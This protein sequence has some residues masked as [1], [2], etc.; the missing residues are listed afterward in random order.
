MHVNLD[1]SIVDLE[2]EASNFAMLEDNATEWDA[3]AE[4]YLNGRVLRIIVEKN[5]T[6]KIYSEKKTWWRTFVMKM[7]KWWSETRW[8][9][10]KNYEYSLDRIFAKD[11]KSPGCPVLAAAS[12]KVHNFYFDKFMKKKKAHEMQT[13]GANEPERPAVPPAG[14][15]RGASGRGTAGGGGSD[16]Y[17]KLTGE[18]GPEPSSGGGAGGGAGGVGSAPATRVGVHVGPSGG[19]GAGAVGGSPVRGGVGADVGGRVGPS[20][21]GTERLPS[22]PAVGFPTGDVPPRGPVGAGAGGG[23]G[24]HVGKSHRK[25]DLNGAK[26][27]R[28]R[29]TGIVE[30]SPIRARAD[31][32][33]ILGEPE[34]AGSKISH[35]KDAAK[36]RNDIRAFYHALQQSDALMFNA[37]GTLTP[38]GKRLMKYQVIRPDCTVD[39]PPDMSLPQFAPLEITAEDT[40]A[41]ATRLVREDGLRPEIMNMANR[42]TPGGGPEWG[43]PAQEEGNCRGSTLFRTLENAQ[44]VYIGRTERG[45]KEP[46]FPRGGALH[47]EIGIFTETGVVSVG[48][49]SVAALNLRWKEPNITDFNQ[50]HVGSSIMDA[51]KHP[52]EYKAY[53]DYN[54]NS[55]RS[56][57]LGAI[58]NHRDSVVLSAIGCGAFHNDRKIMAQI[59]KEVL[60]EPKFQHRFKKITIAIKADTTEDENLKMFQGVFLHGTDAHGNRIGPPYSNLLRPDHKLLPSSH[61]PP[62]PPPHHHRRHRRT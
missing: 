36:G 52:A 5:G 33:Q 25:L 40:L 55:I 32:M 37:D 45:C 42:F 60:E 43:A 46:Y 10:P 22:G 51:N 17:M 26:E 11:P 3:R 23:A 15:P 28:I 19:V 16:W 29:T 1:Q 27:E 8:S 31:R 18:A 59:M 62:P 4:N 49:G 44:G 20:P 35:A 50:L 58:Q 30:F 6:E 24:G 57:L 9:S 39:V 54:K 34:I 7:K 41:A 53:V 14:G 47:N 48:C 13:T 56:F 61:A 2:R 21:V 38:D 12:A